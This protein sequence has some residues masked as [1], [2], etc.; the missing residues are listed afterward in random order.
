MKKIRDI[1]SGNEGFTLIELLIVIVILGV[2]A[3]IAVPN[4]MGLT[5]T[6]NVEAVKS[7]MR[8]LMTE[9]EAYKAQGNDYKNGTWTT[10]TTLSNDSDLDSAAASALV[11]MDL[12]NSSVTFSDASTYTISATITNPSEES[13]NLKIEISNGKLTTT[14]SS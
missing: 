11:D 5:D 9:L 14:T 6:A 8:T 3:A 4:L 12:G 1:F 7:N 13:T 2:L 10:L